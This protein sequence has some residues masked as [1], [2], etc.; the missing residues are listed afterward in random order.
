MSVFDLD[1]RMDWDAYAR[2]VYTAP[3]TFVDHPE[4]NPA[5]WGGSGWGFDGEIERQ[6]KAAIDAGI[7]PADTYQRGIR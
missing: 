7:I 2:G 5:N 6:R 4:W 3:L 1:P